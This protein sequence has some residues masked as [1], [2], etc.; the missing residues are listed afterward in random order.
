VTIGVAV[1][2]E[3][4]DSIIGGARGRY[5]NRLVNDPA[6]ATAILARPDL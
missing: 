1:G 3:K 6:T 4:V 2:R 5:F